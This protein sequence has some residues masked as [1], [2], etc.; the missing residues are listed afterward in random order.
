[1]IEMDVSIT[2]CI[3][4]LVG[5][6]L[7]AFVAYLAVDKLDGDEGRAFRMAAKENKKKNL[8]KHGD[9]K[10]FEIYSADGSVT[11]EYLKKKGDGVPF[12]FSRT[13]AVA[14]DPETIDRAQAK[15][16]SRGI[17][18]YQVAATNPAVIDTNDALAAK[19]IYDV[20]V[21]KHPELHGLAP[22]S[23]FSLLTTPAA[24]LKFDVANFCR[25]TVTDPTLDSEE[26]TDAVSQCLSIMENQPDEVVL[27]FVN[28]MSERYGGKQ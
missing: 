14:Y 8:K 13:G 26:D 4:F 1:M 21:A 11:F 5:L 27:E 3:A 15:I 19:R 23:F 12:Y 25:D 10:L 6:A 9:G 20:C 2:I 18:C 22:E 24:E 17:K 16:Y 28:L 7:G